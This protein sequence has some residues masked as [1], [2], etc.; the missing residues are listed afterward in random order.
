[1]FTIKS[2]KEMASK[3]ALFVATIA[4][5][6]A[7]SSGAYA[8]DVVHQ[9][10]KTEGYDTPRE[11]MGSKPADHRSAAKRES[12]FLFQLGLTDGA[13]PTASRPHTPDGD[14]RAGVAGPH[15]APKDPQLEWT[16]KQMQCGDC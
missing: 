4:A 7:L 3:S 16:L 12:A 8:A 1:M 13:D 15:G 10:E 9:M 6:F 14:R 5:M 11:H 2:H